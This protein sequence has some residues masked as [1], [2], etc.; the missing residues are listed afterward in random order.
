MK[1]VLH[2]IKENR[3]FIDSVF[4]V[5]IT[6]IIS[7]SMFRKNADI[8]LDDG[9]QH[10]MRAYGSYQSIKQNGTDN[11]ISN[12]ANGFGYSWNLFYGPLSTYCIIVISMILNSFNLGFKIALSLIFLIAGLCMYKLVENITDNKNAGLLSAV[13]YITSPYFFTDIYTR[14]AVG[15]AMSFIFIPL[16]FLGLYNLFNTEKNHYYLIFGTVRIDFVT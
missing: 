15:E 3:V 6:I 10:L 4:L 12:F 8:Y 13:I 14:H 11:I 7:I 5:L 1:E 9:S 16:V 2:K